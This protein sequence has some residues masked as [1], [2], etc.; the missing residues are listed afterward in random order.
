MI[1][2]G[3]RQKLESRA[4]VVVLLL[5]TLFVSWD[6]PVYSRTV[7]RWRRS[8]YDAVLTTAAAVCAGRARAAH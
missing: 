4:K 8:Y 3:P 6:D 7:Q 1:K 5:P 2:H